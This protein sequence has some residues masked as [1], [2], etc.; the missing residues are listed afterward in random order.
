[1]FREKSIVNYKFSW[2]INSNNSL[3]INSSTLKLANVPLEKCGH[4][5]QITSQNYAVIVI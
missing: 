5:I 4:D 2:N 3:G 1:M